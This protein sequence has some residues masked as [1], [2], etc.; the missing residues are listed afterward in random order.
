MPA[1]GLLSPGRAGTPGPCVIAQRPSGMCSAGGPPGGDL[2][3]GNAVAVPLLPAARLA[4]QPGQGGARILLEHGAQ[5]EPALADPE[6]DPGAAR[7]LGQPGP[8]EN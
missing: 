4:S 2:V 3:A 5:R 6:P 8:G 1:A 7:A